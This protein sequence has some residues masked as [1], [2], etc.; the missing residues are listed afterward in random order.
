[1]SENLDHLI[2]AAELGEESRKFLESDLGRCI[3]GMAAQEA[4]LAEKK[5][6]TVDPTDSKTIT[7]L[8]NEVWRANSLEQWLVELLDEGESA[9]NVFQQ[10]SGG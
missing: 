4:S 7:A 1:M 3:L 8:Q 9:M 6:S 10:Q 5:L 2:A